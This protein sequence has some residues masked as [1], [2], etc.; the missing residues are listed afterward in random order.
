MTHSANIATVDPPAGVPVLGIGLLGYAFMGR[1]HT[2]AF[3]K[4]PYIY[5]PPPALPQLVALCGRDKAAVAVAARRYGYAGYYTDWHDLLADERVR[6]LDNLGP[7]NLHAE[8]CIVAARAGKHVICEKPLAR[9]A[10][11]ARGMLDAA[12]A[13]GVK[14]MTAFNYRFVP[15]LRCARDLIARGALG[16]IYHFRACYLQESGLPLHARPATWRMDRAAAGSGALGDLGSHVVDLARY[17]AGEIRSVGARTRTFVPARPLP[18]GGT[19]PVD[20]DDAF[21]ATLDFES[22]A[23]GTLEASRLAAGN[24][25]RLSLEINGELGSLRFDLERLNEFQVY[26]A[27]EEPRE[28]RGFHTVLATEPFHP[29]AALWW[30]RGHIIGWEHTFV[31]ELAHFLDCV[32]HD[33][34]VA[35]DG[36]TF[37]DGYRAA[38]VCDAILESAETGRQVDVP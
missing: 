26:W 15:A 36:A 27:A 13:A 34:D 20:V 4:I 31:H 6:V 8:P 14:H 38:L 35:P 16:S 28:T 33:K 22:G 25:N 5:D 3:K 24:K 23:L 2:N 18:G 32:A 11:E 12:T 1:A 10:E 9:N 29:F 21:V 7:N 30:P 37:F 17:L 19:A